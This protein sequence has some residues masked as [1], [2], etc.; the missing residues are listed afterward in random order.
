[1]LGR[2]LTDKDIHLYLNQKEI[3]LLSQ[4]GLEGF[5][6]EDASSRMVLPVSLMVDDNYP[7]IMVHGMVLEV[8]GT[9]LVTIDSNVYRELI[10]RGVT[11]R[12]PYGNFFG[13]QL[14]LFNSEHSANF[15]ARAN[16]IILEM[17]VPNN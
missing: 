1:M 13:S 10:Q 5:L 16:I 3:E 14:K 2:L 12:R 8:G 6:V 4:K 17:Y 9:Y 15:H 11:G 7:H